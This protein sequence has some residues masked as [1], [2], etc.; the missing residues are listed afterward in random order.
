MDRL[1]RDV[2]DEIRSRPGRAGL[3]FLAILTGMLA[4][5]A[6][7]CV[8]GGLRREARDL[9]ARFGADVFAILP[10]EA[11][12]PSGGARAGLSRGAVALLRANM[13]GARVSGVRRLGRAVDGEDVATVAT[14]EELAAVRGWELL[15]G[16]FL[17]AADCRGGQ[18]HAV[19]TRALGERRGWGI[20]Q[21]LTVR[22][23]PLTIVGVIDAGDILP[24]AAEP[25]A[26]AASGESAVFV[27]HTLLALW[28]EPGSEPLDA[29]FV[30][31]APGRDAAS[32]ASAG[33][34]ILDGQSRGESGL[35]WVTPSTLVRHI[36]RLQ[37]IVG[38]AAGSVAAL[39][40]VLGGATL[41][42]LMAANVRARVVEIGL[43]RALGAR[44]IDV[45]A[46]FVAEGVLVAG[47][48]AL[49]AAAAGHLVLAA[50]AGSIPLPLRLDLLTF[51]APVAL[52]VVLGAACSF[53]P[54]R[55]AASLA[56]SDALR[57]P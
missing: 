3:S 45:A 51:L 24:P 26:R 50:V 17:D 16:R 25:A 49:A 9:V 52:A 37:V 36:R 53:A 39:C 27:P 12:A 10:A 40:L 2:C 42:G 15:R 19:I 38:L 54:A 47:S 14:D 7:L 13:P 56:P 46:L 34:R 57:N 35:A 55:L 48:A 5:T 22:G 43:R 1:L 4:L 29:V 44:P 23:V 28:E 41:M 32:S 21:T 33:R 18:R 31:A 8:A 20:G 6:L 11:A 30:K